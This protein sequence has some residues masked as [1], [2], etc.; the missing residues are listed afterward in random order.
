MHYVDDNIQ[1]PI[2]QSI[3]TA[4]SLIRKFVKYSQCSRLV[5]FVLKWGVYVTKVGQGVSLLH[6]WRGLSAHW[7]EGRDSPFLCW[8]RRNS[9]LSSHICL[10]TIILP[11]TQHTCQSTPTHILPWNIEHIRTNQEL[12]EK[13]VGKEIPVYVQLEFNETEL[14]PFYVESK[15]LKVLQSPV[16]F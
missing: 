12:G 10:H 13:F 9:P 16:Y 4:W 1:A 5:L 7:G 11:S 15:N 6:W 3:I 2:N 8:L 14:I